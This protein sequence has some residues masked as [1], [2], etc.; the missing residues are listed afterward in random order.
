[1]YLE[2]LGSVDYA[3]DKT[4]SILTEALEKQASTNGALHRNLAHLDKEISRLKHKE[5]L[6]ED[7]R[8]IVEY[9]A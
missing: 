1:M 2:A 5:A 8:F 7:I 3:K 9:G 4:I 6:F